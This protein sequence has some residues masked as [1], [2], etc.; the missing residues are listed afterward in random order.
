MYLGSHD[1]SPV[2]FEAAAAWQRS[3]LRIKTS[4]DRHA[5]SFRQV[6]WLAELACIARTPQS[7]RLAWWSDNAYGTKVEITSCS[8]GR[9]ARNASGDRRRSFAWRS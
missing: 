9:Q 1:C 6:M 7:G 4:I 2:N 5:S 3:G 8:R